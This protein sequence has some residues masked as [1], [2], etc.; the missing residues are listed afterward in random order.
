M[1]KV[2]LINPMRNPAGGSEHRTIAL[3]ELLAEICDVQV[4]SE[5][6]PQPSF[7]GQVPIRKIGPPASFPQGGNLVFV[8][9]YFSIG[10]WLKAARP[11]RV[12]L[13][14]NLDQPSRL[15]EI[16]GALGQAGVSCPEVVYASHRIAQSTPD[17]SG[18]VHESPI[19]LNRFQPSDSRPSQ[20]T[21]GRLSRD[22]LEKHHPGD[23]AI[24][25]TLAA[26]GIRIRL[27]G[28]SCLNLEGDGIEVL[29]EA[30]E[31]PERFLQSLSC[32]FY[33]T[34]PDWNEAYGRVV[35]E[36]MACG[37][38][39]VGE[40]HQGY[41]EQLTDGVDALLADDDS[42]AMAAI[43]RLWLEEGLRRGVG[44][45]ARE[46]AKS[47]YGADYRLRMQRFYGD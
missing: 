16:Y 13:I 8:G 38:P 3:F 7:L 14:H 19:D 39:V 47:V 31:P 29:A 33:R 25:Q 21:V 36:A 2:H 30:I 15:R 9:T 26:K 35:L 32:F 40:R 22:V 42:Q 4:W 28:A 18:V 37:L 1:P 10:G 12:I 45:A 6:E 27:M 44:Q 11:Q 46:R 24:Y 34:H 5:E 23:V 17:I 20:F 43:E 41:A